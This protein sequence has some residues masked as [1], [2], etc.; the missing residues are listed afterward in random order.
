MTGRERAYHPLMADITLYPIGEADAAELL[1]FELENR[2]FFEKTIAGFGDGYY[3]LKTV[4]RITAER[5]RDWEED[6]SY[7]YLIRDAAGE[8]IGRISLFGVRRGPAQSAEVGYRIA[9]QH[10]GKGYATAAV[11]LVLKD[12]FGTYKLHRL[13]AATSPKN[14]AS[15]L[16]LLKNGFEFWGRA[17]SSYFLNG[18]WEDTV[19]LEG[20]AD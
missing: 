11:G 17:R 8:L 5:V 19:M 6:E 10:S 12:A 2:T 18:V 4:E 3:N 14:R 7:Y 16:V 13:E 20:H 1:R 9:E 15:Q